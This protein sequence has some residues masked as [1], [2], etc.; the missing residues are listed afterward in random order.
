MNRRGFIKV[1]AAIAGGWLA[2]AVVKANIEKGVRLGYIDRFDVYPGSIPT[3]RPKQKPDERFLIIPKEMA[4]LILKAPP[5]E[6]PVAEPEP[7]S[8]R[9]QHW[10]TARWWH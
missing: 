10:V 1:M 3:Q 9:K 7:L 8:R 6:L 2:P 5:P 4:D